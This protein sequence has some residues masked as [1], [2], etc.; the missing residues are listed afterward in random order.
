[1]DLKNKRVLVTARAFGTM[2][3]ALKE[4]LEQSVG[5]VIYAINKPR[6]SPAELAELVQG[7]HGWIASLD[8]I[9]CSVFQAADVL[10]VVSRFG[11]GVDNIDLTGAKEFGVQV[12]NTPRV[13]ANAVAEHC[14]GLL[15]TL[16]R[17]IA[18]GVESTREGEWK[19]ITSPTLEGKTFG[20]YGF[21]QIGQGVAARLAGFAMRI[22]AYDPYPNH[23]AAQKLGVEF[24]NEDTLLAQSDFLSL[25]L[26]T[27]VDTRGSINKSV[28]NKMKPG[29][30][31]INTARG[32]LIHEMDLLAALQSG[33]LAGAAVDVM[34]AEPPAADHPL[35]SLPNM[36]VTPHMAAYGESA[37]W[38]MGKMAMENV[39]RVL[40]GQ[41]PHSR[42]A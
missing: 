15:L 38:G 27:N 21:G 13:N 5:E 1:M 30:F 6:Y 20:L 10:A 24:V 40:S 17:R 2:H 9:D 23:E 26:P 14:V 42:V 11:V 34:S 7:C 36:L 37:M 29:S 12:C 32:E 22:L 4:T 31:L 39:L 25:H 33:Q 16:V 8:T 3:P 41:E 19:I 35:F 18:D 28:F